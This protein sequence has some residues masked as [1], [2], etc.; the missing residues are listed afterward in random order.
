MQRHRASE[1]LRRL[2]TFFPDG[3]GVERTR[4]EARV[5]LQRQPLEPAVENLKHATRCRRKTLLLM[6]STNWKRNCSDELGNQRALSFF[7]FFNP[8]KS[9]FTHHARCLEFVISVCVSVVWFATASPVSV[10]SSNIESRWIL[11]V[12]SA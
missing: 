2:V 5:S 11:S 7:F 6:R 10:A 8:K 12:P 9:P 1:P 3:G 4:A